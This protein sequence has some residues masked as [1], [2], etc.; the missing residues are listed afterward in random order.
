LNNDLR[1]S[2]RTL[3]Y[4]ATL[5]RLKSEFL[6]E[7]EEPGE[8]DEFG[9]DEDAQVAVEERPA[10]VFGVPPDEDVGKIH[11]AD[12]EGLAVEVVFEDGLVFEA[13][14]FESG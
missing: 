14:G 5:L 9:L 10:R 4:A 13:D 1:V 8:E 12:A 2:G 11:L 3:F 7:P 6:V